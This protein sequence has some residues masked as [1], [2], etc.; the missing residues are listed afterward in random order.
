MAK[1]RKRDFKPKLRNPVARALNIDR[2]YRQRITVKEATRLL[3]EEN[4]E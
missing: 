3:K 4:E 1:I 2:D